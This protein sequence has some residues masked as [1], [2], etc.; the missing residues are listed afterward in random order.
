[1]PKIDKKGN[2]D[3]HRRELN[4]DQEKIYLQLISGTHTL[5]FQGE[6]SSRRV[7]RILS[8]NSISGDHNIRNLAQFYTEIVSKTNPAVL[9][10]YPP[11]D[12]PNTTNGAE[13]FF[14]QLSD[15][16]KN[17]SRS[18]I[19]HLGNNP[20]SAVL[21]N[22]FFMNEGHKVVVLH[23]LWLFDLYQ[24][25]GSFFERGGFGFEIIQK[26]LGIFGSK[27][28]SE[29]LAGDNF[30]ENL[31]LEIGKIFLLPILNRADLII[32]HSQNNIFAN[33]I[34]KQFQKNTTQIPLPLG[35][36][37]REFGHPSNGCGVDTILISGKTSGSY[38]LKFY[39]DLIMESLSINQ[40]KKVTIF[41][42]VV[43][44]FEEGT[45]KK[46]AKS[47]KLSTKSLSLVREF[48]DSQ[49]DE[50]LKPNVIGIRLGVGS[51]GENSGIVRDFLSSGM[52]VVT[53]E[54]LDAFCDYPALHMVKVGSNS[55]EITDVIKNA[56]NNPKFPDASR[57]L[58][59]LSVQSISSYK[60]ALEL[61][62]GKINEQN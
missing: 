39:T 25:L 58:K 50:L 26:N 34:I 1:V 60:T 16:Y 56:V 5:N 57:R 6:A 29:I 47:Q 35:Y 18:S 2:K 36:S 62:L 12:K 30:D 44:F 19:Y 42:E 27:G 48:T 55:Q 13:S 41:G 33:W 40:I 31:R 51:N 45:L 14:H 11:I 4:E 46:I 3:L 20:D 21:L 7:V 10:V 61:L 24:H 37:K 8:P 15:N 59:D 9:L 52:Q 22:D 54:F 32:I 43:N 53:D 17:L 38:D 28:I 23:D 49:W